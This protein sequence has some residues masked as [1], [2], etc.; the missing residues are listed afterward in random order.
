MKKTMLALGTLALTGILLGTAACSDSTHEHT[1]GNWTTVKAATIFEDGQEE[2]VCADDASHKESRAISAIGKTTGV[3]S[4]FT[5]YASECTQ[6]EKGIVLNREGEGTATTSASTYF[7]E[8]DKNYDWD[9][10]EMTISFDLDLTA[11]SNEGDYTIFVL[12]FNKQVKGEYSHANEIRIGIQKT[13]TGYAMNDMVSG[14][15]N[16]NIGDA[17]TTAGKNFTSST[18]TA[19]F[20]ISY[21]DATPA[22]GTLTYTLTVAD[23]SVSGTRTDNNGKIV[24]LRYLWNSDLNK[25]GV[26]LYNL[27]KA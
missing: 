4:L 23:Q 13:A 17:I 22:N 6:G 3:Y 7:G 9:G 10:S 11:L 14:D 16:G 19:S 15:Y 5:T 25:D 24:G 8:Q 20:K 27:I 1:W 26:E 2:R 18:V 21:T 12:G